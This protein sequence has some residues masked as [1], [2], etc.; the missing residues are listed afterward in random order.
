MSKRSAIGRRVS[1]AAAGSECEGLREGKS[2]PTSGWFAVEPDAPTYF[3]K[4]LPPASSITALNLAGVRPDIP[5]FFISACTNGKPGPQKQIPILLP[6]HILKYPVYGERIGVT[7][8]RKCI[9]PS[10]G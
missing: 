4:R 6:N 2:M 9:P 7:H 5:L 3:I 10:E 1:A 8:N